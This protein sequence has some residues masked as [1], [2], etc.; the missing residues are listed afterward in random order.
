MNDYM[1]I[2]LVLVLLIFL[3]TGKKKKT[4]RTKPTYRRTSLRRDVLY[5]RGGRLSWEEAKSAEEKGAEGEWFVATA[6]LGRLPGDLFFVFNDILVPAPGGTSQID[7]VVAADQGIFVIETKNYQGTI[8]GNEKS[9]EWYQFLGSKQY[10]FHNPLHQNYGHVKALSQAI[11]LPETCFISIVVFPNQTKLNI[12]ARDSVLHTYE[13]AD[14]IRNYTANSPLTEKQTALA[15]E[16]LKELA[17]H[18]PVMKREHVDNVKKKILERDEKIKA[19]ICPRCGGKLTLRAGKYG[20]FYGC[21]N[22][23]KCGFTLKQS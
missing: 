1:I 6:E 14:Y 7:H 16:R 20:Q 23:P 9:S 3:L 18:D 21:S 15:C 8:Y 4:Y 13:L 2:V 19:G 17:D 10:P 5:L 12:E 22:Y 11:Q